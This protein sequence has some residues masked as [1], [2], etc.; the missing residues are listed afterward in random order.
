MKLTWLRLAVMIGLLT[1]GLSN[2]AVAQLSTGSTSPAFDTKLYNP[3]AVVQSRKEFGHWTLVCAEL[4]GLNRR[5]CNVTSLAA[6]ADGKFFVAIVVSTTD[7]GKPAA[8]LRMPLL[9]SLREGV[10]VVIKAL[11]GTKAKAK[12]VNAGKRHADF[13]SCEQQI[14]TSI[15]PLQMADLAVLSGRGSMNLHVFIL[16]NVAANQAASSLPKSKPLDVVF[17]GSGFA[18]ALQ[19]SQKP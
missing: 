15:L 7:E 1:Q 14:C 10:E 18:E 9:V 13:V 6:A 16:A 11:P 8:L 12:F 19:A 2:S 4:S 5:F 3:D 17:D